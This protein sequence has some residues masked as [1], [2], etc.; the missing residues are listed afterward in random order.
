MRLELVLSS[1]FLWKLPLLLFRE[2]TE[3]F[4]VEKSELFSCACLM[5]KQEDFKDPDKKYSCFSAFF[6]R[7]HRCSPVRHGYAE[8]CVVFTHLCRLRTEDELCLKRP[9]LMLQKLQAPPS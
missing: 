6:C 3:F 4:A 5:E 9:P 2:M 8:R 1:H 7:R